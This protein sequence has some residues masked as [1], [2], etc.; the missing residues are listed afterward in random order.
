MGNDLQ[1]FLHM[2]EHWMWRYYFL[3]GAGELVGM[4]TAS[5]F[6]RAE[7]ERAMRRFRLGHT[8]H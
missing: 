3:S 4:S 5:Y 6:T 8:I 7:A 1:S 2:D